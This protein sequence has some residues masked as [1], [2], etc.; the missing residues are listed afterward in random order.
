MRTSIA[1]ALIVSAAAVRGQAPAPASR[2]MKVDEIYQEHCAA[3]HGKDLKDGLGGSLVDGEWKHGSTDE[4]IARSI[5]KGNVELGMDPWEGVLDDKQIR[6]MVIFLRERE[7]EERYRKSEFPKPRP[8][9]VTRTDLHAYRMELVAEGLEI[10]WGIAFLPDGRKLVTERRGTLR[11]I[12]ADGK[13]DPDPVLGTPPVIHHGQGG[14]M[15]VALHPDFAKNGWIYLGFADGW[16]TNGR[17]RTITAIVRGHLRDHAWADQEW[18]YR[19]DPKFYTEA[20]VHFG[21]R[22]VFKDGYV[23]FV[24]GER[25]GGLEAQDVTR[26]NG[27]IFRLFDDGRVPPDNPFVDRPGAERGI[28]SYGHR[29]PQ[30]LAF[31]ASGDRLYDTEHGPRGGDELNVIRRGANYGWPVITYGMN[32]DGTPMTDLTAK[33]GMEQPV[34]H[35]TPSIATCG[36]ACY[37]G[38]KFPKWRGDFLCGGLAA[39]EIRRVRVKDGQVLAHEVIMKD[40]G[41]VRDIKIGPDGFIYVAHNN[42]DRIVRLVPAD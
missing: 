33:E 26:P 32:Y 22:I 5:A 38:D 28:W 11:I 35:W 1:L 16:R 20:G 41:R 30:G 42:P 31:D 25:G 39:Q 4:E 36:L 21:T 15:D 23:F 3:C 9:A 7:K 6:A 2:N 27:K 12:G 19:A 40:A 29:N 34:L 8:D 17:P 24:V 37:A 18:I 13:L 10:P 14:M